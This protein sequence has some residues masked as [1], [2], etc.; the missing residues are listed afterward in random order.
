MNATLEDVTKKKPEPTAEELAAVE[1]PVE[2]R[3]ERLRRS[4]QRGTQVTTEEEVT[5][6]TWQTRIYRART[7]RRSATKWLPKSDTTRG[8]LL[9]DHGNMVCGLRFS[10]WAI[11]GSNQ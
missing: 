3:A 1:Q 8:D 6:L 7:A 10:G 4:P 5:P 11:L 2:G 9:P